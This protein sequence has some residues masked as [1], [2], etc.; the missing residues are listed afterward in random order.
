VFVERRILYAPSKAANAGSAAISALSISQ[1]SIQDGCWSREDA[2]SKLQA[3]VL[4]VHNACR[5]AAEEHGQPG[6]YVLGAN[7]AG[8][9]RVAA[10]ILAQGLV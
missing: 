8:F 3:A 7:I 2:D 5:E 9:L 6:N 4:S 10:A 1:E